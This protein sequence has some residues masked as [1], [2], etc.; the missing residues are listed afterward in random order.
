[1]TRW[2]LTATILAPARDI[3]RFAAYHLE[4]GAHRLYL[5]LDAPN[6]EAYDILKAHPKVRI[7]TC[8]DAHW[9]RLNVQRPR[10]HQ[11][12]QCV[13][14]THAYHRRQEVDWLIHMDVD[15]FLVPQQPVA[16]LLAQFPADAQSVRVRPIEILA[17]GDGTA[18]KAFI[19]PGTW[20][21]DITNALYPTYGPY[22]KAGFLSHTAG[23]VF[24][25]K[26]L[27]DVQIR[28][29]NAFRDGQKLSGEYELPDIDLAHCHSKSWDDWRGSYAYR[30]E[31]GSYRA[32]LK[33]AIPR[34]KGG[35]NKHEM[36][37]E[38]ERAEGDAGLRAFFDEVMQDTPDLRARLEER[39]LLRI[40][41]LDLDAACARHFP[42]A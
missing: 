16:R 12:R 3:L 17:D 18:F 29:H 7:Q 22:L 40:V 30:I 6:P 11:V 25:R 9:A 31:K 34:D 37:R 2:G 8:D 27:P 26:G 28:I 24:V 23:K 42:G 20:R 5:F 14:A 36:F 41:D 13:N 10:K 39:G 1:M 38:I 4:Q 21:A 15:E 19:P 32:D 33:P 35:L